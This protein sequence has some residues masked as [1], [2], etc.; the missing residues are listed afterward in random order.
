MHLVA[1][2]EETLSEAVNR[3]AIYGKLFDQLINRPWA[4]KTEGNIPHLQGITP[5]DLREAMQD[6]AHAI[7]HSDKLYLHKSALE[8]LPKV[9]AL[10][11]RIS[12]KMDLWRTV[13][14]A[15]YMEEVKK[16][17]RHEVADD[18]NTDYAIEFLHKSLPEYL[19]AEKIW[20]D[21]KDKFSD[22][23]RRAT[24][25]IEELYDIF[26][27]RLL[28][29]EVT[30]Y[31]IEIIQND[32]KAD[33]T[34]LYHNLV[35]YLPD[36]LKSDFLD[37]AKGYPHPLDTIRAVF[38]GWWTVVSH[39]QETTAS[40]LQ[41]NPSA[42]LALFKVIWS[43]QWVYLNL[44]GADLSGANLS[45][46]ILEGA[47]LSGA[48]LSGADLSGAI[49]SGANLHGANLHGAILSSAILYGA[50][51]FSAILHGTNLSSAILADANLSGA[52]LSRANLA[53]ANLADANLA[54]AIL[55]GA[56]LADANLERAYLYGANLSNT[57][58]YGA[59]LAGA[60]LERANL[61][62]ANLYGANLYGANLYGA[63]LSGAKNL[64]IKQLKSAASLYRC[65]GISEA[66]E[67]EL[68]K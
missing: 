41:L 12:G 15:F 25:G 21:V 9:K 20:R 5:T 29:D 28:T 66:W 38:Y 34:R 56:N 65:E 19:C 8:Q 23:P 14:V 45:G 6:M 62:G 53:D 11:D 16:K 27:H 55:S 52:N 7:F 33:K 46:A 10:Q 13:M 68:E 44:S 49:L 43:R 36:F 50:N 39:L 17:D 60:I 1:S 61:Y 67:R 2:L 57:N 51:L 32:T 37:P 54:D 59:N 47:N 42:L 31:L 63:I 40:T 4:N 48:D 24:N 18:R 35:H 3:A 26:Q 64:T 58:L 30:Q 22:K